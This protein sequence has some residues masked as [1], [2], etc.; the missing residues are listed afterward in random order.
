MPSVPPKPPAGS[1]T[2]RG[3]QAVTGAQAGSAHPFPYRTIRPRHCSRAA[4]I[5]RAA[6][7]VLTAE[8]AVARVLDGVWVAGVMN[9][10]ARPSGAGNDDVR[11]FLGSRR[12]RYTLH[13]RPRAQVPCH[14]DSDDLRRSHDVEAVLQRCQRCLGG[15]TV[16][17]R[18]PRQPPAE[19]D[20]GERHLLVH[21]AQSRGADELAGRADLHGPEAKAA[22][23]QVVLE[24]LN[25]CLV[26]CAVPTRPSRERPGRHGFRRGQADLGRNS[27]PQAEAKLAPGS[28]V[29]APVVPQVSFGLLGSL[30]GKL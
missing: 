18:R 23:V 8:D 4:R 25:Q 9:G 10:R 22:A 11:Q 13:H 24:G 28:Q 19:L 3:G 26:A 6:S 29:H 30:L 15:V 1:A 7:P 21:G 2:E 12:F 14:G 17:P 20:T 5:G 16:A 27:R